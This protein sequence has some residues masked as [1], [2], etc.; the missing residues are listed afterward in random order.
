MS[1]TIAHGPLAWNPSASNYQLDG[2]EN[3]LFG[4]PFFRVAFELSSPAWSWSIPLRPSSCTN[5]KGYRN[6]SYL[7]P[8]SARICSEAVLVGSMIHSKAMRDSSQSKW[9]TG[10]PRTRCGPTGA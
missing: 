6:C 3:R 2:P 1:L 5:P 9:G 10:S 8:I 4:H 7:V